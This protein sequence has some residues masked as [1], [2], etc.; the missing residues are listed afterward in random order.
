MEFT[1]E[2]K[3]IVALLTDIHAALNIQNSVDPVFVQDA[4][5]SG[6]TWALRWQYPGIFQGAAD[7]PA[8][9]KFVADVLQL[10]QRIEES[11]AQLGDDD[12]AEVE[13]K[14]NPFGTHVVFPGFDGNG[15]DGDAY[16]TAHVLIEQLGRWP[17]F[18][19]R[20]LNSHGPMNDSYQRM[21]DALHA[22]RKDAMDYYLSADEIAVLL[23]ARAHP[24]NR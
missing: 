20:D 17:G 13:T 10:W 22:L 3:L 6:R 21:L 7:T 18:K 8:D 19:G 4:V 2:Q 16:G 15:S 11:Y 23:L 14:A 12:R 9:V 5:M 24:D 1:D